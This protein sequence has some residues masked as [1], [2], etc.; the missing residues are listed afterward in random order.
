MLIFYN[1][2]Y[3]S[4]SSDTNTA[5]NSSN[6]ADSNTDNDNNNN[7]ISSGDNNVI[8]VHG[9]NEEGSNHGSIG[10]GSGSDNDSL[11]EFSDFV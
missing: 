11:E 2:L 4:R 7:Y 9:F 5:A 3:K 1:R 6:N 10:S 8:Q